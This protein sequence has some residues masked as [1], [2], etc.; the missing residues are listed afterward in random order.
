VLDCVAD[1]RSDRAE[2]WFASKSPI[3]AA[4]TVAATLGLP[5]DRVTVHVVRGG[6][7]FGRRLFFDPAVEAALVSRAVGRPV[8][9]LWTRADDMHHGRMRP[10]SHHKARATHLLGAVVA[11]EHRMGSVT[12]DGSHGLG[13]LITAVGADVLGAAG[14]AMFHLSQRDPY[15]SGPEPASHRRGHRHHRQRL[16]LR[17]LRPHP[18]GDPPRRH[19]HRHR[20]VELRSVRPG[21]GTTT[22]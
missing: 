3:V 18:P 20:H 22:R 12:L 14:Q 5:V 17:Y 13:E 21:Q 19:R 6:G 7:S 2:L 11:Y 4:Q 8:R 15:H 10:A 9:L 1:V 16:P